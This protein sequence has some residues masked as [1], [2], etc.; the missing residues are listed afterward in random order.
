MQRRPN[1]LQVLRSTET[2]TYMDIS[3]NHI[4]CP[5]SQQRFVEADRVTR[6]RGCGHLF[7]ADYIREWFQSSSNCPVCRYD[8]MTYTPERSQP[9]DIS[10]GDVFL[11]VSNNPLQIDPSL[12]ISFPTLFSLTPQR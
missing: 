1:L 7:H 9:R 6:I 3:T 5:I 12:N 11:D 10:N 8:I 2:N 4:M